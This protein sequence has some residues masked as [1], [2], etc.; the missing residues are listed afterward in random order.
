[1]HASVFAFLAIVAGELL[2][3][4]LHKAQEADLG[5]LSTDATEPAYANSKRPFRIISLS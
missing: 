4:T 1:M 3:A 2:N 5:L